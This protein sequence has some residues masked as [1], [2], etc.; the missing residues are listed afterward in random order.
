[1]VG[2]VCEEGRVRKEEQRVVSTELRPPELQDE[3]VH[4]S[5]QSCPPLKQGP[6]L[7]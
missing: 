2:K 5:H 7:L 6:S 1:M 3:L 4:K